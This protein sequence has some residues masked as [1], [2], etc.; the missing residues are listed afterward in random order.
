[1]V[2]LSVEDT[3]LVLHIKV[4]LIK[5]HKPAH[6]PVIG[7]GDLQKPS[8]RRLART[9]GKSCTLD[10]RTQGLSGSQAEGNTCGKLRFL[11]V[12]SGVG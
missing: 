5:A 12:C 9:H 7:L 2:G 3:L 6:K 8:K 4:K 11:L 1:M 10:I